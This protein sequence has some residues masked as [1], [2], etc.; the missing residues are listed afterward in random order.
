MPTFQYEAMNA[1][2]QEVKAE[3]EA[4]TSDEAITRIRS[5]GY[6]S[7]QGTGKVGQER[8]KGGGG[9]GGDPSAGA[10]HWP[11][12]KKGGGRSRSVLGGYRPRRLPSSRGSFRLCKMPACRFCAP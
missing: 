3:I 12:K 2:G 8:Q 10:R 11:K 7:D 9:G 1:A 6:F 5:Q 4:N